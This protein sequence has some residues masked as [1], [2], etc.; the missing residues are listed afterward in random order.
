MRKEISSRTL[1]NNKKGNVMRRKVWGVLLLLI[2]LYLS[3]C[4]TKPSWQL[5]EN[6]EL[7]IKLE[8]PDTWDATYF[9]R[10]GTIVLNGKDKNNN[11]VHIE[12][13]GNACNL[14]SDFG[15]PSE[16]IE[17]ESRRIRILYGLDMLT[18][19]QSP[20]AIENEKNEITK[21]MIE[22]PT[23]A[24]PNDS[25]ANQVGRRETNL[26]QTMEIFVIKSNGYFT[27]AYI[28]KGNGEELN[29]DAEK[30]VASLELSCSK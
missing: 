17:S 14:I 23:M 28:Y 25:P 8:K 27:N 7:G 4:V 11:S 21:A 5:Y 10:D 19:V 9:E 24:I 15:S 3:G 16:I 20:T 30:V 13:R 22:V 1:R 29:M 12:I 6:P 26:F 18:I 2:F